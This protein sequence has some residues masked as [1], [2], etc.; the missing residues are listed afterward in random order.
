MTALRDRV[1]G[2]GLD[3]G[4]WRTAGDGDRPVVGVLAL[5]G[6]VLEN[7]RMLEAAGAAPVPVKRPEELSGLDGLVVPGGESTAIGR[8]ADFYGLLEPLRKRVAA[9]LPTFG[10]CAGAIL[11]AREA[12][13]ADGTRSDQQLIGGMDTV[14][15]RNAFGRQVASFE[16]DLDVDGIE[17]GP[18]HAVFI[19][20]PWI[21]EAG[22][23]VEVLSRVPTPVGDRIVIAREGRF[24]ASAFHPELTGD[25]RLHQMFV[26]MVRRGSPR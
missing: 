23:D 13:L 7:L 10:T 5:Q 18:L 8:L 16:A 9:D 2:E 11:L 6:D 4:E 24:L 15:R 1:P 12:L 14:V 21:E 17:G 19:R 25:G 20:A 22:P 3:R 26:S